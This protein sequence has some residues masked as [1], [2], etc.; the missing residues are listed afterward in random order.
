[1][2]S[3]IA[4]FGVFNLA[5]SAADQQSYLDA[6]MRREKNVQ[7][8][9]GSFFSKMLKKKGDDDSDDDDDSPRRQKKAK[10]VDSKVEVMNDYYYVIDVEIGTSA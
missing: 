5:L 7:A 8:G 2:K 6:T 10:I 9:E 3:L 1:M 4:A